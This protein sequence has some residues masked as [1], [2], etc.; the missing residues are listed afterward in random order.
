MSE[1]SAVP[2]PDPC[3]SC[4]QNT[5]IIEMRL[6]VNPKASLAG[7]TMKFAAESWPW[8]VC[9]TCGVEAAAKRDE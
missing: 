5:L 7:A 8:L 6:T 4:G 9:T 1:Q 3:P 2:V